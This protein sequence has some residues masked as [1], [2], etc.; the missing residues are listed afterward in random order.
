M[1]TEMERSAT[2]ETSAQP[3]AKPAPKCPELPPVAQHSL[4][5]WP[6]LCYAWVAPMAQVLRSAAPTFVSQGPKETCLL[7]TR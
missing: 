5:P 4:K 3:A 7:Q 1:I 6:K 2:T